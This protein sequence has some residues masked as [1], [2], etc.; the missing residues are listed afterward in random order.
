MK[1]DSLDFIVLWNHFVK[2]WKWFVISVFAF[3]L[4]ALI[5]LW[6]TPAKVNVMGKIQITDKSKQD[7]RLSMGMA[8]LNSLPMGLGSSLGGS[9]G[10]GGIESE[11]EILMSNN[12]SR[13]VVNELGLYTEYRLKSW[14]RKILLYQNQPVNVTISPAD[15]KKMEDKLPLKL[16]QIKLTITKSGNNYTVETVLKENK[17][18]TELPDQTFEKLPATIDTGLGKLLLT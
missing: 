5:Y 12:L 11:E 2:N 13:D 17:E 9:L 1:E 6:F 15:L 4:V 8:M 14:G 18:K 10:A 7:S 3:L 16:Q